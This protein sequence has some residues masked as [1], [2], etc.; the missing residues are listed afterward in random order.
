[1]EY[2]WKLSVLKLGCWEVKEWEYVLGLIFFIKDMMN[3]C[4]I[5]KKDGY[6]VPVCLS[7]VKL[8]IKIWILNGENVLDGF[9][10]HS[11]LQ[12]FY[13]AANEIIRIKLVIFSPEST[14]IKYHTLL[15]WTTVKKL[16]K[17]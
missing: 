15:F 3:K 6:E 16:A 2:A 11:I 12:K 10:S 17:T 8:M 9:N 13:E 14:V 4:V 5:F 1:M 7:L